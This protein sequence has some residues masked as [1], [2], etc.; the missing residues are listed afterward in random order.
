MAG[1]RQSRKGNLILKRKVQTVAEYIES[2]RQTGSKK[3]FSNLYTNQNQESQEYLKKLKE[4]IE[5]LQQTYD[6]YIEQ[7]KLLMSIQESMNAN[8]DVFSQ[9]T[10][11]LS[12][13]KNAA[14]LLLNN[15]ALPQNFTDQILINYDN[16][17]QN[18]YN[19][20]INAKQFLDSINGTIR[21]E[22][23][24]MHIGVFDAKNEGFKEFWLDNKSM[25][26]LESFESGL[27][28]LNII[29]GKNGEF[30]ATLALKRN[31][32]NDELINGLTKA[33]NASAWSVEQS[34]LMNSNWQDNT[35]AFNILRR[36]GLVSQRQGQKGTQK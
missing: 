24:E 1:R 6:E 22:I 3:R 18:F 26:E 35:I 11:V 10:Q 21:D 4:V 23:N 16:A 29:K 19:A 20:F 5:I 36:I 34:N 8:N 28:K 13:E 15:S 33:M 9:L 32:S 30:N 31:L 7:Y 12:N 27:L 17:Y 25:A 2:F 14:S